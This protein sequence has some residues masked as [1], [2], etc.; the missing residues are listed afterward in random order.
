MQ[1]THNTLSENIRVKSVELLNKHLAVAIDLHAQ[2]KQ[3]I[4]TCAEQHSSRSTNC[5]ISSR[6]TNC[7]TRSPQ[8]S[9]TIPASLPNVS[10]DLAAPHAALFQL[11]WSTPIWSLILAVSPTKL[12][13]YSLFPG[14]W[15]RSAS[16]Y[17]RP[18]LKRQPLAMQTP[19]ICSPKFHTASIT[20]SGSSNLTWLQKMNK[21]DRC[22]TPPQNR[23]DGSELI[24]M[25]KRVCNRP[26]TLA[27]ARGARSEPCDR[28]EVW[29]NEGGAR[30]GAN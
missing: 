13:T 1:P 25:A 6:P 26:S 18:L 23:G 14:P 8:M 2:V 3:R 7:S 28:I 15:P 27:E 29:V 4:G 16:P 12:S 20:S 22:Q 24:R 11:L 19:L 17:E 5:T 30:G 21:T 9:R 10:A